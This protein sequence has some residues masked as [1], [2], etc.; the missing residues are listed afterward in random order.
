MLQSAPFEHIAKAS[1]KHLTFKTIFLIAITNF[2][3]C[4][5]LQ[6]LQLGDG[7]VNIQKKGVTFIKQSLGKQDR[8][9]HY[10]TKI[11][12]LFNGAAV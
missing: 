1:L 11:W 4:S 2:R 3:R 5:D 10:G 9:N 7:W 6:A 8:P 12:A